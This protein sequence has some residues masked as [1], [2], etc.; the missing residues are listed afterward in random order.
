[1][2]VILFFCS[3]NLKG[4]D[5]TAIASSF[6]HTAVLRN[7]G[8]AWTSGVNT[9]GKLGDGTTVRRHRL[10]QVMT[11]VIAISAGG[12]YTLFLKNDG[13]AWACGR[14]SSGQLGDG[15]TMDRL[16]PVQVLDNVIAIDAG[17]DHSLF[18]RNDNTAWAC[19]RNSGGQLGDGTNTTRLSPVQVL[20]DV[21]AISAGANHSLFAKIDTSAWA[22]GLNGNGQLGDGTIVDKNVPTL[23]LADV[24]KVAAGRNDS[25]FLKSDG[26]VWAV[27]RNQYGQL[28]NGT[29]N[30]IRFLTMVLTD[31]KDID[32]GIGSVIHSLFIKNDNTV[33]ASGRNSTGQ[34]GQGNKVDSLVAV[35]M[36]DNGAAISANPGHSLI[37]KNDGTVFSTGSNFGW[38]ANDAQSSLSPVQAMTAFLTI[39]SITV[40]QTGLVAPVGTLNNLSNFVSAEASSG[41]EVT[42]TVENG[43]A[44]INGN[45]INFS[46]PG[47]VNLV[48][49][50]EGDDVTAAALPVT[51]AITVN[52][53]TSPPVSITLS[54]NWLYDDPPY[55]SNIIGDLITIDP[56]PGDRITYRILP[57]NTDF[58]KFGFAGSGLTRQISVDFDYN[59]QPEFEVGI[60]ATDSA[61]QFFDQLLKIRLID[62]TPFASF[63][64][65]GGFTEAPPSYVNVIYLLKDE[66]G[67]GMDL[68]AEILKDE[69][70]TF[71]VTEEGSPLSSSE[72]FLQIAK[73]DEVPTTIKTIL[74]LD[75]SFS[76]GSNLPMIREAAKTLVEAM[77]EQQEIAVYSFS[78]SAQLVSDFRARSAANQTAIKASI[79]TIGLGS[80]TTN[81]YG[82]IL[83]MLNLPQWQE[84]FD[85]SGIETGFLIVLTDGSD[86]AGLATLEQVIA[87][88]DT[89]SK[90]IYTVGLGAEL[91]LPSLE[92]IGNAGFQN[93]GNINALAQAFADIQ[94][95]IENN[96]R[97]LYWLNYA[98]PKRG[99]FERNLTIALKNN[100]N[101]GPDATLTTTFNSAPFTD[102]TGGVIINRSVFNTAGIQNLTLNLNG[103]SILNAVTILPPF[104][105]PNYTWTVSNA[106]LASISSNDPESSDVTVTANG[107]TGLTDLT[108]T[109]TI[110]GYSNTIPF[111]I[112]QPILP[113]I[114]FTPSS[115]T[116]L[117]QILGLPNKTYTVQQSTDL[118]TWQNLFEITTD[119]SGQAP[120]EILV[121][122]NTPK[123][124]YRVIES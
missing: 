85:I 36:T 47:I 101:P 68:P 53:N 14:N 26:T 54:P 1:M 9:Y 77:F 93:V 51:F 103:S 75:N 58:D 66:T 95:D 124:F 94:A 59:I 83:D 45:L 87:N 110:N 91:D 117:S 106:A 3:N 12:D 23:V 30:E 35:Q 20:T 65:K 46:A 80:P 37:L 5:F 31:M 100:V 90:A 41:L 78:G 69:P 89:Q 109:D 52:P 115:N 119:S 62:R 28:T 71:M 92:D 57:L 67:R 114:A 64:F 40:N 96:A 11:N 39:Q 8:T 6:A 98:S 61:G 42:I 49:S 84:S 25:L 55:Q 50:Q 102:P 72:S 34:L 29:T 2:A 10:G 7:D 15:T 97:S 24:T 21:K 33:W 38:F 118:A 81:L 113:S 19:G 56:D 43:P 17:E 27:G 123:F 121:P 4:Q 79:D 48:A 116:I 18:I 86:Q 107:I 122:Q 112:G 70:D 63:E 22:T 111:M 104:G 88:R 105:A 82:G 13:T 108:L 120:F 99:N 16:L 44:E 73:I 32:I 60:R 76:V 74:L